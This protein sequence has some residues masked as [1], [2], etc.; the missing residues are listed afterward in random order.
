MHLV[1]S[2][3]IF[4]LYLRRWEREA[5]G[6]S[7][8]RLF[9][10]FQH[11]FGMAL[12][13][14][15]LE[16]VLD[17]AIWTDHE[18]GSRHTPDLLAIHVLLLHYAERIGDVLVSIGEER[19]GEAELVSKLFL[20]FRRVRGYAEQHGAGFL[21]LLIRVAELAGLDGASWSIGAGIEEEHHRFAAKCL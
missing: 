11:L 5:L 8:G 1:P 9:Q 15:F 21:N 3:S 10:V 12:G 16:D 20:I 13:L 7:F 18:R 17:L 19:E 2:D 14:Y 4:G 6:R